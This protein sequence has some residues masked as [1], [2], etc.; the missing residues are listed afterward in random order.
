[1]KKKRWIF[2]FRRIPCLKQIFRIMK[3]TSFL[4]F[5]M[6]CQVSATVF[7]QNNGQLSL[8]AEQKTI[9]GILQLI[10]DQSDYSFMY[11]S[12]NIDVNRKAD[13]NYNGKSIEEV[14]DI[15]FKGT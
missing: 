6:F 15:L 3:L 11:N 8:K 7:S 14:L 12:N 5:V 1:M 10:E 13:I 4:L 2:Q 9:S